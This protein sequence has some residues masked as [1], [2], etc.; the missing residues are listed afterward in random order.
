[1]RYTCDIQGLENC[2]VELSDRWSVDEALRFW[3]ETQPLADFHALIC[4]KTIALHLEC[5]DADPITGPVAL[6]KE[7]IGAMDRRL[8]EWVRGVPHKHM[9]EIADLGNASRLR[10][11]G[12]TAANLEKGN[13]PQES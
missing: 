6:T 5:V 7:V 4:K 13:D 9:R 12:I 8:L 3:D 10:L 11:Y 2:F 1:M